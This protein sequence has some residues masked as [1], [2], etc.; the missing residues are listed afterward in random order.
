MDRQTG[1]NC[2]SHGETVFCLMLA[3]LAKHTRLAVKAAGL[4]RVADCPCL[5]F[6]RRALKANTNQ[7]ANVAAM[8]MRDQLRVILVLP[9]FLS[10]R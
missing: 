1:E 2:C 6:S 5:T 8:W 7:S 4:S 3:G 10:N 9:F